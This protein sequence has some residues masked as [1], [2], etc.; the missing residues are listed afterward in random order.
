M[1]ITKIS[2]LS[3]KTHTREID[4]DPDVYAAWVYARTSP[5]GRRKAPLVQDAFPHLSADDREFLLT[6]ATPTEWQTH[7]GDD[8]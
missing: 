3:G 8:E 2:Q 6:G 4:V 7:F 5:T 1:K